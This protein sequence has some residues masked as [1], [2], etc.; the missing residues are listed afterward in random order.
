MYTWKQLITGLVVLVF[1]F[2]LPTNAADPFQVEWTEVS[3]GIW[4]GIRPNSPRIPVMGTSVVVTGKNGVLIFDAGGTSLHSERI[5]EHVQNTTEKPV[6]HIVISH[7]H[8]DHHLG[9][10]KILEAFPSAEVISHSFTAAAMAGAPMDYIKPQIEDGFQSTKAALEEF[11]KTGKL[12]D[13]SEVP[14]AIYDYYATAYEDADLIGEQMRGFVVT[15]PTRTFDDEL[16]VDL[17]GRTVEL[18]HFGWGNTK[19]DVVLWL[20]EEKVA[21][22]ADLVVHP[23][24]YGFGSY[25][26][27]WV[28]SL[29]ALKG[30]GF[31]TL[32]P[33]HGALQT[34][35][36]YIDLLIETQ[37]LV[38]DQVSA[39][40]TQDLPLEEVRK[41]M[42]FSSVE[43]R[44]TGGDPLLANRFNSW[45]KTPIVEAAFN[46]VNGIE[47][48]KLEHDEG[49]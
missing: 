16:T 21:A 44:F 10:H 49:Q 32:I 34:D 9:I 39:L 41:Q 25:P 8:G 20:P 24:P 38:W 2:A 47:N 17:G 31:S 7:W 5:L 3:N 30:L 22:A 23:T 29:Q 14:K 28:K 37:Q 36:Q 43:V 48:E 42:D 40:A 35:S 4:A 1:G 15:P 33:G 45:F 18:L 13:G 11:V 27:D 19:G 12:P 6:T 46:V 26:A